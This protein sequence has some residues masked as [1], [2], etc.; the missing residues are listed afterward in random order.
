MPDNVSG[1][2]K[3][4]SVT[5]IPPATPVADT[6]MTTSS[7]YEVVRAGDKSMV[8]PLESDCVHPV[9]EGVVKTYFLKCFW[10][11]SPRNH[12]A[13]RSSICTKQRRRDE[14]L[15]SAQLDTT[16]GYASSAFKSL[17]KE[18]HERHHL[19]AVLWHSIS[20]PTI[21]V[22]LDRLEDVLELVF[23]RRSHPRAFCS[24]TNKYWSLALW[25]Q[26]CWGLGRQG[27]TNTDYAREFSVE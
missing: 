23:C 24:R 10:A 15:K 18:L 14:D 1:V 27:T 11:T 22:E 8:S 7:R 3:T 12:C 19:I 25:F 13:P 2:A 5:W 6:T 17:C 20:R 4:T 16:L 21:V 26:R 9:R